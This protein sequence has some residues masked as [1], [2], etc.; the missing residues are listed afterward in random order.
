MKRLCATLV[1]E[2]TG[3]PDFAQQ[4]LYFVVAF[5]A[6]IGFALAIYLFV[7]R[8]ITS[9]LQRLWRRRDISIVPASNFIGS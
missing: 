7:E 2:V 9:I 8:P 3:L 1:R 6:S 4:I 5:A